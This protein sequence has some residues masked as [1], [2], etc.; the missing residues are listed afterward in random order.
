[1]QR[2][3]G[4]R[5]Q[6]DGVEIVGLWKPVVLKGFAEKRPREPFATRVSL[7]PTAPESAGTPVA[8]VRE[9]PALPRAPILQRVTC[10]SVSRTEAGMITITGQ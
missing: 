4:N 6:S 3:V 5:L 9:I 8:A 1:M 7:I 10:T 2:P